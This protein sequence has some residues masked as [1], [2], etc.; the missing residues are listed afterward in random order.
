MPVL[1]CKYIKKEPSKTPEYLSRWR[2]SPLEEEKAMMMMMKI[3]VSEYIN[4]RIEI[5]LITYLVV[6]Q[7]K[8]SVI[9]RL[10]ALVIIRV[11]LLKKPIASALYF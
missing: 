7:K 5:F 3:K 4:S 10:P 1:Q 8:E 2:G 9:P 6:L 11:R